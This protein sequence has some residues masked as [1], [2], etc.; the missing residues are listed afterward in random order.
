MNRRELALVTVCALGLAA[1][2]ACS[3]LQST[4][5]AVTAAAPQVA[6]DVAAACAAVEPVRTAAAGILK[7]GAASTAQKDLS[8]V[9]GAC[10]AAVADAPTVLAVLAGIE[11][12][13]KAAGTPA[14]APATGN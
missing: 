13:V 11:A 9:Q 14:P 3:F 5:S 4:V 12:Q 2:T 10:A 7:G 6:A 8:V 1:L